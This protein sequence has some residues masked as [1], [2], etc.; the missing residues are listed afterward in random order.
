MTKEVEK[1]INKLDQWQQE[2]TQ[3]RKIISS[4]KLEEELKWGKPCYSYEGNN[5]AI[6]QP[7]KNFLAL[8]FFKGTLLKDPKKLLVD[9]GPNS[10]AAR[11]LEFHSVDEI[12]KSAPILKAYLKEAIELERSVKKVEFKKKPEPMPEELLNAFSKNAKFKKAFMELTHGRQRAYILHFSG[13]KQS[14]TR[15]GRIEKCIPQILKGKG[16][17]D[18]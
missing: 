10:Q 18:R 13:A 15:Q 7:F 9:N 8:M 12:A 6:I 5:I 2:I 11:R 16:M 1:Y 14:E 3:L 17:N 4:A